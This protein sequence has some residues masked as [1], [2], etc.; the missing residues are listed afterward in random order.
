MMTVHSSLY[1]PVLMNLKTQEPE[2]KNGQIVIMYVISPSAKECR[3]RAAEMM[4]TGMT[5][6][7]LAKKGW[8][9]RLLE[10]I[11]D[12]RELFIREDYDA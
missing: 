8:R 5:W 6:K 2:E 9:V 11:A 7:A 4:G 1:V 12:E 3:E 10:L